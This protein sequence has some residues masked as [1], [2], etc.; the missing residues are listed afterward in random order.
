MPVINYEKKERMKELI[1]ILNDA[2]K[3]Y[4]SGKVESPLTDDQ[5]DSYMYELSF[6]E[7]A[8]GVRMR[9]SP[10]EMVGFEET[11]RKVEH[12]APVLSLKD[13]KSVDELQRFLGELDGLLSWKLDGIS[14]VLHYEDG[15]LK[16][17]LTRGDGHI[18]KDVTENVKWMQGVPHELVMKHKLIVRGEGVISIG[19]FERIR[20]TQL[21]EKYSNPRNMAAGVLNRNRPGEM[22]RSLSFI[23][24][25]VVYLEEEGHQ[26]N[27]RHKY[28]D[29]LTVLGFKV[30]PHV[31]VRNYDLTAKIE[32]FTENLEAYEFPVDGL[33]LSIDRID[34]GEQRG[35]TA[36]FPKHS[37]A[38]KWPDETAMTIVTGVKWSV[39]EKGLLTPVV[40]F[41]P[42]KLEGTI[43][44]QANLHNVRR[45][46]ELGIGIG[47]Q[48]EVFKANKIIPEVKENYTRTATEPVPMVC[49]HCNF[50]TELWTTDVT[51]KLYCPN[52]RQKEGK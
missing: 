51:T 34:L 14:I 43:V 16:L 18:G 26:T 3:K 23:A 33:V 10:T 8:L 5:Y 41:E 48:I 7:E 49:P 21:A 50:Q 1:H 15:E 19:E 12:F 31:R 40:Q 13:T 32:E 46:R 27:L 29:Y 45:F 38:F 6:L 39:S 52:C 36:R 37:M 28:L 25:S 24:H 22:L 47:D 20:D 11:E 2:R 44:K 35:A 4:Y 30:V 42:I 17:A 9:G